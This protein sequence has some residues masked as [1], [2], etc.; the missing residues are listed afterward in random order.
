MIDDI[1]SFVSIQLKRDTKAALYVQLYEALATLIKSNRLAPGYLLPP[2]RKFADFLNVNAGTVVSAYKELEKNGYIF[3]RKGSGS[4]VAEQ[5]ELADVERSIELTNTDITDPEIISADSDHLLINMSSISLNP[6]IIS[7]EKF[8]QVLIQVLDRDQG[9]AFSYQES[10]GFLPLRESITEYLKKNGI[11]TTADNV[12][13]ISGAQQG[14]DIVSRA[15]L[16]HG[17]YVFTEAPTYPG[18][19]AA[20]RSRGAK[21]IEIPLDK[22]GMDINKLE[23]NLRCFRPRLIYLMPNIQNPTGLSYSTARRNRLMGLARHY[24]I[25]VLEDDYISELSY[26][27]EKP[28]PLKA[29][30]RDDRIIYL[31]SFSKI[32]M[33]GLR[34]AFL[35]MPK[36]LAPKL[37]SVKHLS[38]ISTSGLTQRIFDM[39]LRKGLWQ[40]HIS[41]IRNI[42]EA[43]LDFT[44]KA[45]KKYLPSDIA[46]IKPH[47]GLSLW[48]TLPK[49]IS[50]DAV[51]RNAHEGGVLITNGSSF[52]PRKTIPRY[53]RIS[54]ATIS[55]QQIDTGLQIIGKAIQTC[56]QAK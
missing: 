6:D 51:V 23:E 26:A 33:P 19:I 10:Q 13:I 25:F 35:T 53:I 17:D 20:F 28:A 8:K 36:V 45:V 34:L 54:F 22:D 40:K 21:I 2:V 27:K 3:S 29:L 46:C 30:D 47:G 39:Y 14:I 4:Y 49:E 52:F 43:Q 1:L 55:L 48:L 37:L 31:K 7:I 41:D 44:I 16:D 18:A 42:Y 5:S 56:Q 32:F 24:N 12:Q 38:D 11:E 15:L 9:H 50:A